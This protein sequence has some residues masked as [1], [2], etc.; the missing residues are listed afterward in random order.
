MADDK[1]RITVRL[2]AVAHQKITVISRHD[3]RSL[4]SEIEYLI[5]E[6]IDE[7]EKKHGLIKVK[8]EE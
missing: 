8:I 3:K 5:Q 1:L 6:R 2:E 4:N 7:Y